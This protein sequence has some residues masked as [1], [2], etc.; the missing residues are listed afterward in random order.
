MKVHI[1]TQKKSRPRKAM[2]NPTLSRR[3]LAM[4]KKDHAARQAAVARGDLD[5]S[6][7]LATIDVANLVEIK[8]I[9]TRYGW[10]KISQIGERAA[11]AFWLLVQHADSDVKFQRICLRLMKEAAKKSEAPLS[12]VAYLTDRVLMN[13]GKKQRYG[14]QFYQKIP[15]GPWIIRPTEKPEELEARRAKFGLPT[16]AE[17][18]EAINRYIKRAKELAK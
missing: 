14:T 2:K 17:E 7:K 12:R 9:V 1:V 16:V 11:G 18:A 13:E 3:I 4:A 5:T 8:K 6:K 15:G 10:P